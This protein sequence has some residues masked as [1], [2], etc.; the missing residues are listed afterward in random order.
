MNSSTDESLAATEL[1]WSRKQAEEDKLLCEARSGGL[2]N[3]SKQSKSAALVE[4]K[5]IQQ[6]KFEEHKLLNKTNPQAKPQPGDD[7]CGCTLL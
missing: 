6:R 4:V 5:E 3:S 2:E 7:E 1:R